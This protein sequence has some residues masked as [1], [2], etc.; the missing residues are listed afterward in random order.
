MTASEI[1][2]RW[3]KYS[4]FNPDQK[5]FNILSNNYQ[6][7]CI[8]KKLVRIN[9]YDQSGTLS[10]LYLKSEFEKMCK[11]VSVSLF[12]LFS[13]HDMDGIEDDKEMW[14]L[15]HSDGVRESENDLIDK[16]ERIVSQI[17]K[18]KIGERDTEA[19]R[20]ALYKGIDS[21]V[22][23]MP[24]L[25][26]ETYKTNHLPVLPICHFSPTIHIFETMAHCVLQIDNW[27]DGIYLC[28]ISNYGTADSYFCFVVKSNDNLLAYSERIQEAFPGQHSESRNGRWQSAL[29]MRLF[30]YREIIKESDY[31]YKGYA[32]KKEVAGDKL[33]FFDLAPESY[34]PLLLAMVLLAKSAES[35]DMSSQP[36]YLSEL[37]LPQNKDSRSEVTQALML[38]SS[39]AIC[40]RAEEFVPPFDAENILSG[41]FDVPAGENPIWRNEA[42]ESNDIELF[43]ALYGANFKLDKDALLASSSGRKALSSNGKDTIS[44]EYVA[45]ENRMAAVAFMQGREQLKKHVEDQMYQEFVRFGG[46]EAI[47]AWWKDSVQSAKDRLFAM[48]AE[49]YK[50]V[51]ENQLHNP[52]L[53]T[54]QASIRHFDEQ[55]NFITMETK[56]ASGIPYRYSNTNAF[57]PINGKKKW[58]CPITGTGASI[59]FYFTPRDYKELKEML[60]V[61]LPKILMGWKQSGHSTRGNSLLNIT[62]PMANV[63]TPFELSYYKSDKRYWTRMKLQDYYHQRKDTMSNEEKETVQSLMES[64]SNVACKMM[65][66]LVIGFS[67]RGI[68]SLVEKLEEQ[69]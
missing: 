8:S 45:D 34:I 11:Q 4:N 28:Y 13:D 51:A 58:S 23:E 68:K 57:N 9:Q 35:L 67:A 14:R 24:E 41:E 26:V 44:A 46:N 22:E 21:I 1:L 15:L 55:L 3:V 36:M 6:M 42:V 43:I 2:E 66:P 63:C 27:M 64:A 32:Q 18:K 69:V 54:T 37:L 7:H 10:V 39:S 47:D 33:S 59:F 40:K 65:F 62:D 30:P 53:D 12:D 49:K 38:K 29:K 19:E 61:E 25:H 17:G 60:G 16:I 5:K 31:D 56:C 52:S 50:G 20:T 48:C